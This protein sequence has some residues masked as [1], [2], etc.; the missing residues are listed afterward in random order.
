MNR[1]ESQAASIPSPPTR[2]RLSWDE[3]DQLC[4]D[5][6]RSLDASRFDL[7]LTIARGGLVPA[8]IF[9]QRLGLRNILAASLA[10]YADDAVKGGETLRFL[11]FPPDAEIKGRRVLVVDDIWD[12]G[13]TAVTV[14]QRLL[15]AG[16]EPFIAVLH[17]KPKSSSF[18]DQ[19]PDRFARET[20]D[21]IVYPWEHEA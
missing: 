7:I 9:A 2:Q 21:W 1:D 5:L 19:S 4:S 15:E 14:K 3:V 8:A 18:P 20:G 16:A 17:Y 12:S 10:S 11:E 13:R 6:A